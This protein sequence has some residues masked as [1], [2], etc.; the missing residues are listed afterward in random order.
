MNLLRESPDVVRESQK[1]RFSDVALVDKTLEADALW[2]KKDLELNEMQSERNAVQKEVGKKKK[3]KEPCDDLVAKIAE[4]KKKVPALEE[5]LKDLD[6]ARNRLLNQI[7]NLVDDSCIVSQD[8]EKDNEVV[9]LVGPT[10]KGEHL[11]HH[12]ELLWMI[13][14]YEPERGSK[15]A[16]HRAYFLQD[17]GVMLNQALINY[18]IAFLRNRPSPYKILQPPYFMNKDVMA[19]VAQLEQFDEEL[20]HVKG[21]DEKYLIATSEQPICAFHKDEW[22]DLKDLPKRYAGISTCFRKEAGSSGRDVWGIFRVHQFEK[23]EQFM[24]TD[25]DIEVSR[26]AQEEMMECAE[27]FYKSLGLSYHVVNIVSGELNNAA[28]KK[29]DLEAWFPGYGEYRELVSCSNCTDYQAR[30]MNIRVGAKAEKKYVHMLNSTLCATTRTLSCILE[31]YQTPHGVA[32]PEVLIPYMGGMTMLPFVREPKDSG[33]PKGKDKKNKA[34]KP[35]KA[36]KAPKK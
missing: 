22:L 7:G 34:S 36:P 3:A 27:D 31:N 19:G 16:G 30:S 8:E 6:K 10:P 23:V 12:H 26:K 21:D 11:W 28:I 2:R 33:K 24:I 18:G 25:G 35:G 14:G 4:Y 1:K 15:V 29:Y 20:Y 32:V 13:G 17:V 5:E 9:K